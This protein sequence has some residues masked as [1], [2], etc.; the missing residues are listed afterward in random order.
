MKIL[1]IGE[2]SGVHN[3][4]KKGLVDL[5]HVVTLATDGDSY[6]DIKRDLNLK[7]YATTSEMKRIVRWYMHMRNIL[8]FMK[9][10]KTYSG[11]DIVQFISPF[12][13]QATYYL[14]IR[15]ILRFN[16]K[17]IYYICGTDPVFLDSDK[18][19]KYF[20]FDNNES[21]ELPKYNKNSLKYFN[22]FVKKIDLIIPAMYTYMV[23]YI[24]YSKLSNPIPLPGTGNY[25]NIE[26]VNNNHKVNILHGITRFNFKGS[27]YILEALEE[28]KN[29]YPDIVNVN[30]VEKLPFT[31]YY[32]LYSN[33]DIVVDQCKS[34]DY[35]M[36]AIYALEHGKIVL[37][38]AEDVALIY[39]A[40]EKCPI[41][42]IRPDKNHIVTQLE[43]IISMNYEEI[44]NMQN[45]SISYV[46]NHHDPKIIALKFIKYYQ[47]D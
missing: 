31:E 47:A 20:P 4:L 25:A 40:F 30:I 44:S 41:I 39:S 18:H 27:K 38:G 9:N 43:K 24:N 22:W 35:G 23:G 14:I 29:K 28:L 2:F 8:F 46:K 37:S 6:R 21:D 11:N 16:K 15:L 45:K 36:N 10:Y 19:F 5:G 42:N 32:S 33:A 12:A 3:N 1:L 34:Y 13:I 26:K 17:T 7:P